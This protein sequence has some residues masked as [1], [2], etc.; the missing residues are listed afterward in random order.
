MKERPNA[1]KVCSH[2]SIPTAEN[3][4]TQALTEK[5]ENQLLLVGP[6]VDKNHIDDCDL[7]KGKY[8]T[9]EFNQELFVTSI[10]AFTQ[11]RFEKMKEHHTFLRDRRKLW[12]NRC[13]SI[14]NS[15]IHGVQAQEGED[16]N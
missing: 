4:G 8:P 13:Y 2:F 5:Q 9:T 6:K 15:R 16:R 7:L 10:K 14:I 12:K 1:H 3:G 11:E